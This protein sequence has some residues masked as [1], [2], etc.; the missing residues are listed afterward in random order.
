MTWTSRNQDATGLGVYGL[1]YNAA[2]QRADV[3]FRINSTI[4]DDQA[5]SAPIAYQDGLF[6][7]PWTSDAQDGA[8]EGI[9]GQ[10]FNLNR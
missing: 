1:G 5:Q 8:L 7:S 9:Y 2:G 4:A 3:E 6:V 10:R